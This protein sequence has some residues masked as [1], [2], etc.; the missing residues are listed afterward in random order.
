MRKKKKLQQTTQDLTTLVNNTEELLKNYTIEDEDPLLSS[1]STSLKKLQSQLNSSEHL[2]AQRILNKKSQ[3]HQP[4]EFGPDPDPELDESFRQKLKRKR[5]PT[6]PQKGARVTILEPSA[7]G[8]VERI[9]R[10]P[11]YCRAPTPTL[12]EILKDESLDPKKVMSQDG[13]NWGALSAKVGNM[14]KTPQ[15]RI[16][17]HNVFF[18]KTRVPQIELDSKR[19]KQRPVVYP[20]QSSR[21]TPNVAGQRQADDTSLSSVGPAREV[22]INEPCS[23]N[24][25]L[26][27]EGNRIPLWARRRAN[28]SPVPAEFFGGYPRPIRAYKRTHPQKRHPD[29]C[30][31]RATEAVG[32]LDEIREKIWQKTYKGCLETIFPDP[33]K[34]YKSMDLKARLK[35]KIGLNLT[36]LECDHIVASAVPKKDE[37]GGELRKKDFVDFLTKKSNERMR[38]RRPSSAMLRTRPN[39][40]QKHLE[41]EKRTSIHLR[42]G[43][44]RECME[45]DDSTDFYRRAM[46]LERNTPRNSDPLSP[47]GTSPEAEQENTGY[48]NQELA[49]S[50]PEEE[51]DPNPA[52]GQSPTRTQTY[53]RRRPS[54][55]IDTNVAGSPTTKLSKPTSGK[56]YFNTSK[57]NTSLRHFDFR[58]PPE[59]PRPVK[60]PLSAY[61]YSCPNALTPGMKEVVMAAGKRTPRPTSG[62][63]TRSLKDF[64]S[65]SGMDPFP[66]RGVKRYQRSR[67]SR[68]P[69]PC[70][71]HNGNPPVRFGKRIFCQ[72]FTKKCDG[73]RS[74][75][76]NKRAEPPSAGY[77]KPRMDEPRNLK[78]VHCTAAHSRLRGIIAQDRAEIKKAYQQISKEE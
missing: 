24:D 21:R 27:T 45:F 61:T 44:S 37:N 8:G 77:N 40:L 2:R 31:L 62:G 51:K 56:R 67:Y 23:T 59:P 53:K 36:P 49:V 9:F 71:R 75:P 57:N 66:A 72:S 17:Q 14:P 28:Q 25:S 60:R 42:S 13:E 30:Y 5:L 15:R 58:E 73:D 69:A 34:G 39:D 76:P 18:P 10:S 64:V 26:K 22:D 63:S 11:R 7:G 33:T 19:E 3:F 38:C 41:R 47:R 35:D 52:F 43:N 1:I 68:R 50:A 70:W 6:S 32:R 20:F 78:Q 16:S 54:V 29:Q 4:I 65:G 46:D 55:I 74:V 48:S 12:Q